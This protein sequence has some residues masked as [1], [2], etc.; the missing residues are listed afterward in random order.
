MKDYSDGCKH[1]AE[2]KVQCKTFDMSCA[3]FHTRMVGTE[4]S[5]I[6]GNICPF[7]EAKL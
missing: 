4:Y 1:K 7:F 2:N 5:F 6:H 3:M